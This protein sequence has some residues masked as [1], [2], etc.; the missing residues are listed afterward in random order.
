MA[1]VKCKD[2]GKDVSTSALAC[3]TCGCPIRSA[4]VQQAVSSGLACPYCGS[5]QIGKVRGLQGAGEVF[6]AVALFFCFMIPAIAYYIYVESVPY[7]S[8]CGRRVR[9]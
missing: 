8:G 2:C 4:P 5:S 9:R 1:L 7:C 6:M 3:P